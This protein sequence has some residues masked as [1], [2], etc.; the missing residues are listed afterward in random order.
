MI[1][2]IVWVIFPNFFKSTW[3]ILKVLKIYI[4]FYK[5]SRLGR[6]HKMM[7]TTPE[8]RGVSS[9]I[10]G[11]LIQFTLGA[12]YSFGNMT[13]YMTSYMRHHGSPNI[14][15]GDTILIQ[16]VWGMTQGISMPLSGFIIKYIGDRVAIFGGCTIFSAGAA[17]TY[18]TIRDLIIYM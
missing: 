7:E 17:L 6:L 4:V 3:I 5:M 1:H 10:G 18:F 12:F 13:T 15:Y 2:K 14:T 9:L 8:W 16:S 11:F